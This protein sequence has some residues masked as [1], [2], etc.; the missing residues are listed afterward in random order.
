MGAAWPAQ[1][2]LHYVGGRD[3]AEYWIPA[4]GLD[5]FNDHIVGPIETRG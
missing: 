2:E 1:F 5:E 3:H 4:E